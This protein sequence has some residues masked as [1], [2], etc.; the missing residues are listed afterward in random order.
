MGRQFLPTSDAALLAWSL[1]FNTLIT[2]T[3]TAYGL[4]AA[5][6]TAYGTLHTGYATAL[7]ACEPPQRTKSAVA[8]KNLARTNLK[9]DARL[10]AKLVDGNRHFAP[11]RRRRRWG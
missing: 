2:A 9:N 10:L 1:N 6:A 5:L 3:P 8:A 7:A 11:T 4:T